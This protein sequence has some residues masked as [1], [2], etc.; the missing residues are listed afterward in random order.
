MI[1][2]HSQ[3]WGYPLQVLSV[4][5]RRAQLEPEPLSLAERGKKPGLRA[6]LRSLFHFHAWFLGL[7]LLL[8]AV[9]W[10]N[11]QPT[12]DNGGGVGVGPVASPCGEGERLFRDQ[13]HAAAKPLLMKCLDEQGEQSEILVFLTVIALAEARNSEATQWGVRAATNAPDSPDALY[14]YGRALLESG[15]LAGALQQW[16]AAIALD[17]NHVGVLEGLAKLAANQGEDSKAYGLL[18]QMQ[19]IGVDEAWVYRLLSDLTRRRGLW[20]ASLQ[21]WHD[22]MEREGESADALIIAGELSI[23]VGD[24]EGAIVATERAVELEPNGASYGA[25]GEAMF[26]AKRFEEAMTALRMAAEIEP[27]SVRVQ[28]NL[29]NV[30]EIMGLLEEAE[31]HFERVIALDPEDVGGRLNYAV[32]LEQQGRLDEALEQAEAAGRVAPN[33]TEATVLQAQIQE[34]MGHHTEV[35]ALIDSLMEMNPDNRD[36]LVAWRQQISEDQA[37]QETA[38]AAGKVYLQHIILAD[39]DA[40]KSFEQELAKE[41]DFTQLAVR[42]S[43]GPTAADG[44]DIGWVSPDDMVEPLRGAITSLA[45]NQISPIIESRGRFHVFRRLR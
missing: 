20:A 28:F 13:K 8:G 21:H 2:H 12:E 27:G 35:L 1:G 38:R 3:F 41:T 36:E 17:T 19:R 26:A 11:A 15:D 5:G 44:G 16:E 10:V 34:K 37:E 14:W 32:H 6:I 7:V 40:V 42:F 23:M 45:P 24:H 22:Y 39:S 30:L 9:G 18:V 43:L 25:L 29:A 31:I 33:L 4:P